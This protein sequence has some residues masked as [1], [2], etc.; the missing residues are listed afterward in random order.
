MHHAK[1]KCVECDKKTGSE[2]A[3]LLL[4]GARQE[5]RYLPDDELQELLGPENPRY[6]NG[7]YGSKCYGRRMIL[8]REQQITPKLREHWTKMDDL[9]YIPEE[10]REYHEL[11]KKWTASS[12]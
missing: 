12:G 9:S 5:T 2:F 3:E 4:E 1:R 7:S 6:L 10:G 8:R 11:H